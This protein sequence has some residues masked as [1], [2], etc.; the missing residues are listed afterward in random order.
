M[1]KTEAE[2]QKAL[3]EYKTK[4]ANPDALSS[5]GQFDPKL[6]GR[7]YQEFENFLSQ[8]LHRVVEVRD[9]EI[10]SLIVPKAFEEPGLCHDTLAE[11]SFTISH[12]EDKC[13]CHCHA[14]GNYEDCHGHKILGCIHC[15]EDEGGKYE[16]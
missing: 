16:Y 15:S 4:F 9:K 12:S 7:L 14:G 13:E 10:S 6:A 2:I 1:N 11:I 3:E 5:K 8:A